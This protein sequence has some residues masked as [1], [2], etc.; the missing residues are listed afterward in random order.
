MPVAVF[1]L[2]LHRRKSIS[3]GVQMQ[4]NFLKIFS[5]PEDTRW[6]KEVPK[7]GSEGSRTHLGRAWGP[8]RALVGCAHHGP[9]LWYFFGPLSVF[10]PEKISQKFP[11]F[12]L[13]S[14]L[15]FCKV[16]NKPKIAIGTGHYVNRLVPKNNIKLL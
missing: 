13:R 14:V 2:F 12:G 7:G 10:G 11:S 16:K 15:I 5:G 4:R 6:A 1:C 8:R 3:N 9:P